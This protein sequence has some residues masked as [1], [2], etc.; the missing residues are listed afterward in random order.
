MNS[1]IKYQKIKIFRSNTPLSHAE[2]LIAR[3]DEDNKGSQIFD[4]GQRRLYFFLTHLKDIWEDP[5][6]LL[7]DIL[8]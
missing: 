6:K 1:I 5:P 8:N 2:Q 4:V 7:C 3:H